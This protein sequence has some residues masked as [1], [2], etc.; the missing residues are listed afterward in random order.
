MA[1][2]EGQRYWIWLAGVYGLGAKRFDALLAKCGQPQQVW[3]EIG[4]WMEPV[5][6]A[7]AYAALRRA[8]DAKAFDRLFE[9]MERSG[10]VA[11]TRE[12]SEYPPLL[13]AIQDAPPVLFVRGRVALADARTLGVVG[14]RN[15]TAYGT[16]MARRL[17]RD[18]SLMGVTI[19]SGLAR[20]IDSAAH[21]G[22]V[23][24]K[25]RTVAVLGSG[26]DVIY[27]PEHRV[28][29]DEILANGGSI[30]SE[31]VPGTPPKGYHFP[32][33]N[34][35]ISGLSEGL[36]LVEAA[37]QSG[38]MSTVMF[39]G[40]QGREVLALPGQADSPL[41]RATHDLIRDGAR[42]VTSAAEIFED[43][44]WERPGALGDHRVTR[45]LPLTQAEQ[46]VYN[47]LAGGPMDTDALVEA[48][49]MPP[50]ELGALLTMLE[51]Q[52]VIRKLPGRRVELAGDE[53]Q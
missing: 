40:E 28:L 30:V 13:R 24:A 53:G 6:G 18:L 23:D 49:G 33:R 38:A 35:I 8:R 10:A 47:L 11:V 29:A 21:R 9:S 44:G 3:E 51:L 2:T 46:K 17:A 43:M 41:S 48:A 42:L 12:D 16:R 19:V 31:Q 52:G 20:G 1:Y 26:V 5:I 50:P 7:A 37:K 25:A 36:L 34:R 14:A 27:P 22:T 45:V 4:P 15:G 39:A 32:A